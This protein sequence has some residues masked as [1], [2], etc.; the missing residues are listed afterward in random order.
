MD[1]QMFQLA[2]TSMEKAYAPYSSFKVG[3]AIRGKNGKLYG[4]CNVEN[5]AYP[6]GCCAESSAIS[7][8]VLDGE[9]TID[10]ICVIGLGDALVTPCGGCRQRIREFADDSISI[11]ICGQEGLRKTFSL[12]ELLPESFGPENLGE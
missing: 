3:A 1:D 11:Y 8:M 4:G 9:T 5:A 12:G 6:Q 10:A 2:L 7:A